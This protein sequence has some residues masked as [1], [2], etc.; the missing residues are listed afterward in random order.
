M[1]KNLFSRIKSGVGK[2]VGAVR[3]PLKRVGQIGAAVGRFA[4]DHHQP[5]SMMLHGAGEMSGNRTLQ[6]IGG[7]ALMGSGALTT[8]G[9][10]KDYAG[11][12]PSG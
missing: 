3:E 11:A 7:A 9:Y 2:F 5:I 6:N 10:G 8:L 1:F 12:R 4:F